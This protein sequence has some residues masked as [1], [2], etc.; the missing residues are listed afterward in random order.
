MTVARIA[1]LDQAPERV[2]I[3]KPSSLGDVVTA[4]PVLRALRRKFPKARLSWLISTSCAS[5]LAGDADLDEIVPFERHR[6]GR[7]WRS[8]GSAAALAGLL[9]ALRQARYDW[10]IDLQG[11]FRSGFFARA[12]GSPIRAGFANARE[13]A[14]V[15][16]T[17]RLLPKSEHT[18]DRNIELAAMLGLD[19]RREDMTLSTSAEGEAFAESFRARREVA[20]REYLVFV[21][22]TRWKTKLYPVRHWRALTAALAERAPI[23]IVGTGADAEMCSRIARS[24][25]PGV[26]DLAGQTTIP[27]MVGLIA[28]S[29]CVVCSD[30]AAQYIAQAV[31]ADVVVLIGPTR[32]R[33][34]GPI[35]AGRRITA[36]V[37]C[38]G[39][40]RRT[41]RHVTCMQAI[42]PQSVAAAVEQSLA[43][44]SETC[45]IAT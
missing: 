18:V 5:L 4:V 20:G 27:Q 12:S 8:A 19:A 39:C 35:L 28:A 45:R 41:C 14:W 30:S 9:K 23:A 7:A 10:V 26:I 42:D 40:L 1:L 29:A 34:T 33:H 2:L 24:A 15:F 6:L 36:P 25:G 37:P 3:I 11:L 32:P 21:P 44:R 31:G 13:C 22:P 17:H 16:Y 43:G 38:Q